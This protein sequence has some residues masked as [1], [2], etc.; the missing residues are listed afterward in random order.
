ML[1]ARDRKVPVAWTLLVAVVL[2]GAPAGVVA[3][4]GPGT[5]YV[6]IC[7]EA[8]GPNVGGVFRFTVGGITTDVPVGA[9]SP[10]VEVPAGTVTVTEAER[11]GISVSGIRTL[12]D[13]R[14]V[15]A[16]LANRLARIR[17]VAGDVSTQTAVTFTNLA[18]IALL[19]I[20]KVAGDGVAVGTSFS[21]TAGT[22][23][24]TV[25]AGPPPGG[26]CSV[27]GWFPVA[28][29]V[30]IT[31]SIP[32]G[33]E[34]SAIAVAPA[35]RIVGSANLVGGSVI[36][37]IATG[38]TEATFTNRVPPTVT[39]TTT[40]TPVGSTTTTP[41]GPTTTLVTGPASTTT[42]PTGVPTT[43]A[44]G[45][46]SATTTTTGVTATTTAGGGGSS[47]TAPGGGSP[48]TTTPG[49]GG[50]SSTTPGSGGGTTTTAGGGGPT[51]TSPAAP[52]TTLGI[53]GVSS[54][55]TTG[56][57]MATT[58]P[59][60]GV[61]TTTVCVDVTT[62]TTFPTSGE[63]STTTTTPG[64][65]ASP[66]TTA[67]GGHTTSSTP[68]GAGGTTTTTPAGGQPSTTVATGPAPSTTMPP[69]CVVAPSPPRLVGSPVVLRPGGP[70]PTIVGP[71]I[72]A[73]PLAKTGRA[74]GQ[75]VLLGCVA[76]LLGLFLVRP[77]P[78]GVWAAVRPVVTTMADRLPRRATRV[79]SPRLH[80]DEAVRPRPDDRPEDIEPDAFPALSFVPVVVEEPADADPPM[81]LRGLVAPDAD[82]RR[83][84][85]C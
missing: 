12:P 65:A 63:Q 56:V 58:V 68:G 45:A 69:V 13:S 77:Q 72:V 42:I 4:Q 80:A 17:V 9:C 18:E 28:T 10:A 44:G 51:S 52:T 50:P 20:C 7:K 59:P 26:S 5:G 25:P 3:L 29:Y 74:S 2:L 19:K 85:G 43:T 33:N 24:V 30:A 48:T 36:V 39:T 60:A 70:S 23:G 54:T 61:T 46:G 16:D 8:S 73:P 64:G 41:S 37:R 49:G 57:S 31:E 1:P 82:P 6:E 14:L 84:R 76:V 75:L 53:T 34:V 38:V 32:A 79:C 67:A 66:T 55:T 21:F 40:T 27:A 81:L 78:A 62:S 71:P 11:P 47:T 83:S 15:S 22:V 35:D